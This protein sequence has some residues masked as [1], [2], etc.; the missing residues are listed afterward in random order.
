MRDPRLVGVVVFLLILLAPVP[1]K[2]LGIGLTARAEVRAIAG[3]DEA[4]RDF[5]QGLPDEARE[6][7]VAAV[8][9]SFDRA[10]QSVLL[11]VNE[12][13][14]LLS[15]KIVELQC[16]VI[17]S[18]G[19]IVDEIMRRFPWLAGPRP[20]EELRNEVREQEARLN[21]EVEPEFVETIYLDIAYAASILKCRSGLPGLQNEA[22]AVIDTMTRRYLVWNRVSE[23]DCQQVIDCLSVYR[24]FLEAL[25]TTADPR[26]VRDA[27]GRAA[28]SGI[29]ALLP[30]VPFDNFEER[31]ADYYE[32]EN[33]VGMAEA[34]RNDRALRLLYRAER[35]IL[36]A[37]ERVSR[38]IDRSISVGR[39]EQEKSC[40]KWRYSPRRYRDCMAQDHTGA[41]LA[42]RC[43]A[44]RA[45]IREDEL[46]TALDEL[47]EAVRVSE[48]ARSLSD[49]Y[50]QD[51][52]NLSDAVDLT[53]RRIGSPC[54]Q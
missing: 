15:R 16:V 31:L 21:S 5:I 23:F 43:D 9:R 8:N 52:A 46:R 47:A 4:T 54:M 33:N 10:D 19:G 12:I 11:Y 51:Q 48:E 37:D 17:S 28:L 26:D 42:R 36:S 18:S 30:S 40:Q 29:V 49:I 20:M 1:G 50:R 44:I 35:K 34:F 14:A 38:E 3:L 39:Q 25:F 45:A 22:N 7:L 24:A 32:I 53:K 2:S 41:G 6:Q 13:D 27:G